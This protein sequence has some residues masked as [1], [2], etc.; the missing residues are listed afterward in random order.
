MTAARK[1]VNQPRPHRGFG[2]VPPAPV[3]R[4]TPADADGAPL[5]GQS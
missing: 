1:R 5:F 3:H 4:R 2:E